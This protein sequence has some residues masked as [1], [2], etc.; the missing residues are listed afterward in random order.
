M[1]TKTNVPVVAP[2]HS[3]KGC[4][5]GSTSDKQEAN[6]NKPGKQALHGKKIAVQVKDVGG[7]KSG[8]CCGGH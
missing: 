8:G 7:K 2:H 1:Q 4:C 5:C 3:K 6:A